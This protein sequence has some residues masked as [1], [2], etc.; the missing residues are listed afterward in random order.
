MMT[1][2]LPFAQY[3]SYEQLKREVCMCG[4]TGACVHECVRTPTTHGLTQH[5]VGGRGVR[6][7]IGSSFRSQVPAGVLNL[8]VSMWQQDPK[9]C[10]T[11][12][13]EY[14]DRRW[15][16][17]R[18]VELLLVNFETKHT[19]SKRTFDRDCQAVWFLYVCLLFVFVAVCEGHLF[20]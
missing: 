4:G 6:P 9:Q 17:W 7:R 19:T 16:R 5:K 8:M 2:S 15:G 11:A 20:V 18:V 14:C 10:V 13:N 3:N 12:R 1:G